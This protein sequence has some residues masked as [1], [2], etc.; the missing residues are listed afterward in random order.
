M[1]AN[2]FG[3]ST[4]PKILREV[5]QAI[6]DILGPNYI[7]FQSSKDDIIETINAFEKKFGF[8]QVIGCVDGTHLPILQPSAN[9]HD[10][11]CYKTKYSLNCQAICDEKGQFIDVEVKWPGSVHDARVY[12]NSNVNKNFR[13][14]TLVPCYQELLQGHTGVPPLLLGDLAYPLLP[15]LMKEN[16]N[17]VDTKHVI[18]NKLRA[19]RNQIE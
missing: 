19:A 15:S 10:F 7:K 5:V 3:K 1:T 11:F 13:N 16:S 18:F 9:A 6:I 2:T 17:C 4:L 12:V 14:K 8:P